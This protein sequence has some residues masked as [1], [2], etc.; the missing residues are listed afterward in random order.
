MSV[1]N[2]AKYI[3]KDIYK[4]FLLQI[5]DQIRIKTLL[6]QVFYNYHVQ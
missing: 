3:F 2:H 6:Q 5:H 1:K 4:I